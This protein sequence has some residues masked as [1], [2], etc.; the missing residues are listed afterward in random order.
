MYKIIIGIILNAKIIFL[1]KI[2][3]YK[4]VFFVIFFD[5]L[6]LTT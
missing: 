5:R 1:W 4:R 6:L 3:I 2:N